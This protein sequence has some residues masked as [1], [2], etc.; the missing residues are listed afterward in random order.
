M[1]A[2]RFAFQCS[3]CKASNYVS[4]RNRQ[5]NRERLK[6]KKYCSTC[7]RHT[8]HTES[9]NKTIQAK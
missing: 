8:E 9:R 7:R 5:A 1:P 3:E 6:R 4:T 2:E